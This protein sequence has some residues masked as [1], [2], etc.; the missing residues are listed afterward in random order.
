MRI[1]DADLA[2]LQ[3]NI[4]LSHAAGVG[5][6]AA[7]AGVRL[8]LALKAASLSQGA[9]GVRWETLERLV[10][11]VVH[12]ILPVVRRKA[13]SARRAISRPSPTSPAR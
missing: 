13:P 1:A 6:A 12:D 5:E 10:E 8:I 3:S 11:L 7:A 4:V 2:T 9:S